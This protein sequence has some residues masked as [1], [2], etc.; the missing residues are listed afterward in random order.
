[1]NDEWTN[2]NR[3][4]RIV[5][6]TYSDLPG[7]KVFLTA[8][9]AGHDVVC[10]IILPEPENPFSRQDVESRFEHGTEFKSK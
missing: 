7:G 2:I 8:Q 5:K 9:I 4:G 10:S 6:F 1:M 3:G